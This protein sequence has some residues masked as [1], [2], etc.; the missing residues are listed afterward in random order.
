MGSKSVSGGTV[1]SLSMTAMNISMLGLV[2]HTQAAQSTTAVD[3]RVHPPV[4]TLGL[5][6]HVLLEYLSGC[7]LCPWPWLTHRTLFEVVFKPVP[8]EENFEFSVNNLKG[9]GGDVIKLFLFCLYRKALFLIV[10][11]QT[12][13]SLNM[14]F[15]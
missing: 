9:P 4:A 13:S 8:Y 7:N 2:R 1:P 10:A 11:R 12:M 5:W 6:E 14:Q 3:C 15:L